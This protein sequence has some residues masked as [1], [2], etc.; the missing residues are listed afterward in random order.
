MPVVLARRPE[1]P[2]VQVQALFDA[3]F[4]ADAGGKLGTA[5]FAMGMLRRGRGRATTH[6][7][8]AARAED[9]GAA[10]GASAALDSSSAFVSALNAQLDPSLDLFANMLREPRL[11]AQEIERVRKQWLARHRAARRPS[12]TASPSACCRR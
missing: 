4:A 11:D 10:V 2:V 9:L 8:F 5:A 7:A 12:P 6:S 3:G 1:I